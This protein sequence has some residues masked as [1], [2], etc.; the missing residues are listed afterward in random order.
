MDPTFIE[1][2][3]ACLL[4]RYGQAADNTFE[5][6]KN[7]GTL[8]DTMA[9]INGLKHQAKKVFEKIGWLDDTL[10]ESDLK[11]P[12]PPWS[13]WGELGKLMMED[14]FSW[15][16]FPRSTDALNYDDF[17]LH[18]VKYMAMQMVKDYGSQ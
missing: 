15:A 16:N 9:K 17:T 11:D 4:K 14:E 5:E 7:D 8:D 6:L 3:N 12:E 2:V 1:A 13:E 10:S 18:I